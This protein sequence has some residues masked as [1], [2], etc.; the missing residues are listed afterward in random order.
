MFVY[1]LQSLNNPD[2]FYVG[3]TD[4]P[5]R[6]LDEHNEGTTTHTR[7]YRPWILTSYHWFAD[8]T[9]ARAFESYLKSGSGRAFA[10]KHL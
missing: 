1:T 9:K 5:H 3:L 8:E 2:R 10:R 7:K 6:R 4:D